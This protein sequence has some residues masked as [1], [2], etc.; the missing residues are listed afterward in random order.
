M[1]PK[2]RERDAEGGRALLEDM[3]PRA[4]THNVVATAPGVSCVASKCASKARDED[5]SK[6]PPRL[7]QAILMDAP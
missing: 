3:F 4:A 7:G 6:A 2:H 1:T 5:T